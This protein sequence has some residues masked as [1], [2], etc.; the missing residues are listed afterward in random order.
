MDPISIALAALSGVGTIMEAVA[1]LKAASLQDGTSTPE[2]WAQYD[3]QRA[4]MFAG[5]EWQ[6][7]PEPK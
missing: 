6:P 1:K 2:Q 3:A 4:K 5:P 7:D